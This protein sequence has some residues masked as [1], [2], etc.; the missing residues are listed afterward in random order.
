MPTRST[1]RGDERTPLEGSYDVLICGASFAGLTV[2]RELAGSGADVLVLD[3]YEIGERQT[4]ACAAPTEW[5]RAL[6]PRGARS[7]RPSASWSPTPLTSRCGRRCPSPSR[8]S[9]TARSASCS[10]SSAMP[11]SRPRRSRAGARRQTATPRSGSAPTAA[12]SRRRWSSTGSAG[13]GCSA[14]ERSCSRPRRGF[15]AASRST[16]GEANDD[17][18]I[19]IER[20]V[21]PAGYGWSFPADGEVRVGVGSFDPRFHV[22]QPTVELAERLEVDAV[23]YQGNWIPHRLRPAVDSGVFFAG[24]SAGHCLPLTAEGIR[25]AF[26]FAIACGRELRARASTGRRAASGRSPTTPPSRTLTAGSSRR[27]CGCSSW[28][29]ASRRG[30]WRWRCEGSR[31]DASPTG[32]SGTT[33]EIAPPE[34]AERG[35]RRHASRRRLTT[36]TAVPASSSTTPSTRTG[37]IA[38][39][40]RPRTPSRSATTE[41]VSCPATVAA[42]TPP[43][44]IEPTATSAL[45]T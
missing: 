31:P 43:A 23:R 27:C 3:R 16:P 26:Y 29:P 22:K 6:G 39:C 10:G 44:P 9:T 18:E 41:A 45:A 36:T 33:C 4:S 28:S 17:L 24:D 13:A 40:S 42:A 25:T 1:K 11:S 5:L 21:V 12:R 20:G 32:P 35:P 19:W 38:T 15:R 34:F 2:A 30:C 8:P 37:V 14:Q 7:S